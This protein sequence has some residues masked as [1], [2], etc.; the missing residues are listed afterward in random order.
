[1]ASKKQSKEE[2]K[3]LAMSTLDYLDQFW[4]YL[5]AHDV[6]TVWMTATL[7]PPIEDGRPSRS[8]AFYAL[9]TALVKESPAHL[10]QF[11]EP[12]KGVSDVDDFA[13]PD[14]NDRRIEEQMQSYR[15]TAKELEMAVERGRWKPL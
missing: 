12:L 4:A 13:D 10:V 6:R 5:R 15:D 1:M 2:N 7:K 3:P 8:G 9:L 11:F 14:G